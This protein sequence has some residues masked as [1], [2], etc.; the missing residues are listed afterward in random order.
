MQG[1]IL[2]P[3]LFLCF[4]ND[5]NLSTELLTLLFADDTA[6]IESD[7]DLTALIN[8]VNCE[9]ELQKVANWFRTN[10]LAVNVNKTKYIIFRPKGTKISIDLENNGVVFNS[11]ELG[12]PENPNKIFKLGRIFNENEDKQERTYKFLG[13]LLDEYLS[14]N[15]HC[16]LICKKLAKSNFIISRV[17][18]ML[19]VSSLKT[20]YFALIHPHLLYCLPIFSCTSPKNISKIYRMQKKAIR[21]ITKSR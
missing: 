15:A 1:S 14:F 17:K 21:S 12:V 16:D 9:C 7:S 4:I 6:I 18:N 10:R 2:G 20:L 5:L 3:I 13:I 19:P 11:N 8:R